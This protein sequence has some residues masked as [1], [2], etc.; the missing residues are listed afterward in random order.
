MK[1]NFKRIEY[2][3]IFEMDEEKE[4]MKPQKEIERSII[5]SDNEGNLS[6]SRPTKQFSATVNMLDSKEF[7]RRRNTRHNIM[8]EALQSDGQDTDPSESSDFDS[9][10]GDGEFHADEMGARNMP[11]LQ[12]YCK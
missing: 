5:F 9:D 2:K 3:K 8:G 11:F 7:S 10:S 6:I 1:E 12:S 4:E